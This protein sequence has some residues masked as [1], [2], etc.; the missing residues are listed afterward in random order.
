MVPGTRPALGRRAAQAIVVLL[1]VVSGAAAPVSG[2]AAAGAPHASAATSTDP[3]DA[4]LSVD[5]ERAGSIVRYRATVDAPENAENVRLG[6]AFGLLN[7][8]HSDGFRAVDGDYRL[9]EGRDR[10]TLVAAIDL[11]EARSTPLGTVG[12]DGPFQAGD[13]WAFAPS[14][15][16]HLSWQAADG[17]MVERRLAAGA[18]G[19][20]AENASVRVDS[21][22][23]VAVGDRFVFLGAH[24]VRESDGEQSVRLIA[25]DAASFAVGA[26]RALSLA[27]R[28]YREAGTDPDG[29][30]TAFVLPRDARAGGA[31]SGTDLWLRADA[32]ELTVAHEFAHTALSLRTAEQTRWLG[33]AAAEYVA[34]RTAGPD[35]VTSVLVSRVTQPDA[36]LADR[37]S[38]ESD[39]VAYRKGAAVLA[40]LDERIRR[41]SDGE[42][43]VRTVLAGLSASRGV[44]SA[45]LRDS[46]VDAGNASTAAWLGGHV[47]ESAA[48]DGVAAASESTGT[49]GIDRRLSGDRGADAT[50]TTE[51]SGLLAALGA[52]SVLLWV[53]SGLCYRLLC[54]LRSEVDASAV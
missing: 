34:Y 25:P 47:G 44:D 17:T 53:V 45:A 21:E 16:F 48:F 39:R 19:A 42:R 4:A 5:I 15:R 29:P 26:D 40:L 9:R 30:V 36:P 18:A 7:V 49:P 23:S 20:N 27:G 22:S 11:R 54:R 51:I 31:A 32:S 41:V 52:F 14:P 13:G 28:S 38:W 43:S 6:G 35:D 12:P 24:S 1:V 10:G 2:V 8:T 37:D 3:P 46:V 50:L 33:E